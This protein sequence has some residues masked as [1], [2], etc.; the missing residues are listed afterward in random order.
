MTF[1]AFMGHLAVQVF[2]CL[3]VLYVFG[4]CSA[5]NTANRT[6]GSHGQIN[7]SSHCVL[8]GTAAAP[9]LCDLTQGLLATLKGEWSKRDSCF[10]DK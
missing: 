10:G 1:I 2:T 5:P 4:V 6:I 8:M 9:Y 7:L 3:C